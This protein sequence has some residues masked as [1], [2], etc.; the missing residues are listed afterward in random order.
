MEKHKDA[1]AN[2]RLGVAFL[3]VDG[4][5]VEI[6]KDVVSCDLPNKKQNPCTS[7]EKRKPSLIS[8][9]I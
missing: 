6:Y 4:G 3:S 7:I 5:R 9:T 1:V 2:L 8:E